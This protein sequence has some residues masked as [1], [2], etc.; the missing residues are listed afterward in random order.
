MRY[1]TRFQQ[2]LKGAMSDKSLYWTNPEL[3]L[4]IPANNAVR[5]ARSRN[6]GAD[7]IKAPD[8]YEESK[9][10]AQAAIFLK[11]MQVNPSNDVEVFVI[12]DVIDFMLTNFSFETL[13][14]KCFDEQ[15]KGRI[16]F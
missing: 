13:A 1:N 9:T 7:L 16:G 12:D 14:D 4:A 5:W 8:A 11:D 6:L 10:S 15:T 2:V 3:E